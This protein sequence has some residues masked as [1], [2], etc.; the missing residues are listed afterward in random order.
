MGDKWVTFCSGLEMNQLK[1][2]G[3]DQS[4]KCNQGISRSGGNGNGLPA[5][6]PDGSGK[7][8]VQAR[9]GFDDQTLI[10][11]SSQI[12]KSGAQAAQP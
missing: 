2:G 4:V 10:S 1:P 6:T 11:Q 7:F 8:K 3:F 5:L 12:R 9:G